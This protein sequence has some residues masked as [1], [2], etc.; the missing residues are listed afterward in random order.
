MGTGQHQM[1]GVGDEGTLL[2]GVS[3][4]EQENH[5][6]LP[7]VE[8]FNDPVCE[9]FP[10]Q[11]PVTVGLSGPDGQGG[12]EQQ[13]TLTGPAGQLP[14]GRRLDPQFL[15]NLLEEILQRGGRLHALPHRKAETEC[16]S[17]TD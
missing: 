7:L 4:P 5:R 11:T 13:H 2:P 16:L 15:L 1:G 9:G 6:L 3:A 12:V 14:V 8:Q 10:S 17:Q